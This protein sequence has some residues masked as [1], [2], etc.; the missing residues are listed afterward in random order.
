[1]YSRYFEDFQVGEEFVTKG[2][3]V[4]DADLVNF[5]GLSGN[6]NPIHVDE[7]FAARTPFKR[8]VAHGLLTLSVL[9]GLWDRLGL[10]ED[11]VV[12]HVA[13]TDVRF[14][15]PVFVGDSLYARIRVLEKQ[16]TGKPDRGV[17]VLEAKAFNQNNEEVLSCVNYLMVLKKGGQD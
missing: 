14:V 17:L 5:A 13:M 11:T 16:D 6:F 10:V 3:T 9:L 1:M 4:T 7:H 15:R 8:R 2:R 12:A